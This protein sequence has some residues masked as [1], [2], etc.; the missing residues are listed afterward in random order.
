MPHFF[1][2][3][4]NSSPQD[5]LR[6]EQES[7]AMT[8]YLYEYSEDYNLAKGLRGGDPENGALLVAAYGCMGCH[9]IQ[10]EVDES[11]EPSYENIR[12]EQGPNLIGLGSKTTKEWLFSWLKNSHSFYKPFWFSLL[13]SDEML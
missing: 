4:N 7:L 5:I 6:S 8:E 12:L 11:Y 10:P 2:K 13:A 3:G 9:Q 1:K